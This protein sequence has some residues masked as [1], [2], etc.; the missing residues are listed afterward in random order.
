MAQLGKN[1]NIVSALAGEAVGG[2]QAVYNTLYQAAAPLLR[3]ADFA[4]YDGTGKLLY[5]T[6]S[7]MEPTL[8]ANWGLLAAARDSETVVYRNGENGLQGAEAVYSEGRLVGYVAAQVTDSQFSRLFDGKYGADSDVIV[9]DAYWDE[10]Y[11]PST[12]R[13]RDL[14]PTLRDLFLSGEKLSSGDTVYHVAREER[15]GCYLLLRQPKPVADWIM[16]LLYLVASL[17]ILLCLGLGL[18]VAMGFS[19]QLFRPIRALNDAMAAVEGGDLDARV[20]VTGADEMSQLAGRFNRMAER[21]QENLAQ[22]IR[23]QQELGNTQIRMMQAQLN[24][25]FLYNTLDTLKWMGKIHHI[26]EVSTISTDLADILRQSVSQ[27]EFVTLGEE[28]RLLDR[29]VEIQ[30]IR[31]EGKFDYQTEIDEGL[32]DVKIPKLMLQPLVENAIIHGFEDGVP[33]EVRVTG[34]QAGGEMVLTVRDTGRGMSRESLEQFEAHRGD[35]AGRHLGLH[36]VDAI[37][38]LRYGED[39]GLTFLP[40]TGGRGTCVRVTLPIQREGEGAQ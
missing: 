28:L 22:S 25:H 27:E 20:K 35:P 39:H 6:G 4:L 36:N 26:P 7:S 19:R 5:T 12:I 37:L 3:E 1:R 24:P 11:L 17:A 8:P 10:V 38:R 18:A 34:V 31:F 9:L 32:L 14:V 23:Q 16:E 33:G 40:Q 15:T 29:Y 13:D 21:L 2:R 30:K